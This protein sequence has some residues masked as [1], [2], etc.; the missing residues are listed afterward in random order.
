MNFRNRMRTSFSQKPKIFMLAVLLTVVFGSLAAQDQSGKITRRM[1]LFVGSNNGGRDR[2]T[3]RYAVS[4]ARSVSKVFGDMGGIAEADNHLLVEP[5]VADINRRLDALSKELVSARKVSQRTELVFYYSGH[6][7]EEGLLLNRER[8]SYR[9]LREKINRTEADMRIVILDSC[10]SGAI[11]RTKGGVKTRPFLFDSS[12]SA[13]GYAFLTSSSEDEASQESDRIESSYFTHS[14]LAGLRGAAD[15]VGDGRVTLNELYRFAY[16]ETLASTETSIYGAQHPSY[17]MQVSGSG[18]VV[19]TDIK[20]TSASLLIDGELTGRISIRDSSDFLVAELTKVNQKPMEL[21]L[22]SGLYRITIQKGDNFYRADLL[23]PENARTPLRMKDFSQIAAASGNRNRGDDPQT[24]AEAQPQPQVQPQPHQQSHSGGANLYTFFVNNVNENFR[25]PLIGFVNTAAG[26]H[27]SLQVGFI[28][29]NA[30]NFDGLQAGF[31]N[32]AGGNFKGLQAGFVNTTGGSY[33]GLQASFIN[34]AGGNFKGLQASFI[35]TTAGNFDGL[36][37]GF[38]NTTGKNANGMQASFINISESFNGMQASFIN[39]A[40]KDSR[41]LQTGFVNIAKE[42]ISGTQIGFVNY[43]DKI[44]KGIPIGFI[45]IVKHGGYMA[46]EYSFS[47]FFPVG[48]SFKIGLEKFYT[49]I[50]TGFNPIVASSAESIREQ[51]TAGAGFGSIIPM[52]KIFFFNPEIGLINTTLRR[53]NEP[54]FRQYHSLVP[55]FGFNLGKH[56]SVTAGPSVV[57]VRSWGR[58]ADMPGVYVLD[59]QNTVSEP[60]FSLYSHKFSEWDSIIVG[61]RAAVRVRF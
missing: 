17:D 44:E 53:N 43:A 29:T 5:S 48:L 15:M 57:W 7:D 39:L 11:T 1:G 2:V 4:D 26:D 24:Q 36:Q 38:I 25:F 58:R 55:F 19:L 30:G 41:G 40:R 50:Y 46:L 9:D 45:S 14:V 47:E 42:G 8:Y 49:T 51:F 34:T 32:T 27:N 35:N 22:Q 33:N 10:S 37:A 3:L 60:L 16:N 12:V 13:E 6:S 56:F 54:Y 20:E 61:A 31:I 18:D 21:G 28:N 23:L 52:G 59:D